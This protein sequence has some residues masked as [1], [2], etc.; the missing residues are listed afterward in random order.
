MKLLLDYGPFTVQIRLWGSTPNRQLR[1]ALLQ[2][3]HAIEKTD[4]SFRRFQIV[5]ERTY[6]YENFIDPVWRAKHSH[7]IR[8]PN[9]PGY[10]LRQKRL[11]LGLSGKNFAAL[12]GVHATYLSHVEHGRRPVSENLRKKAESI[13][14]TLVR[15][16]ESKNLSLATVV[17]EGQTFFED[18]QL[19]TNNIEELKEFWDNIED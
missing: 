12:L 14:R 7:T 9:Q 1:Q 5:P 6:H 8:D 11:K 2:I 15:Q 17:H 4:V 13:F 3:V 18:L 16:D 19:A 10:E